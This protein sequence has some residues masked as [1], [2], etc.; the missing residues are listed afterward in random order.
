MPNVTSE[1]ADRSAAFLAELAGLVRLAAGRPR[2]QLVAGQPGC[3]WS[4]NWRSERV[5]VDPDDIRQLAPDLCR[6]LA[7]HE[8][9]HAAITV[10]QQFVQAQVL[11]RLLPLINAI[12]DLRIENELRQVETK[13][14]LKFV[15]HAGEAYGLYGGAWASAELNTT[16]AFFVTGVD[17]AGDLSRDPVGATAR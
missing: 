7:L 10:V 5:T 1:S 3:G 16:V 13:P 2:L 15:G 4:F 14:D 9:A 17:P 11:Q 6:G 8:A 12:E